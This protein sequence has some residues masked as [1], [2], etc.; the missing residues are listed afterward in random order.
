MRSLLPLVY[1]PERILVLPFPFY[2]KDLGCEAL[3]RLQTVLAYFPFQ[4]VLPLY[5]LALVERNEGRDLS[6]PY[7]SHTS[8]LLRQQSVRRVRSD[9]RRWSSVWSQ[10]P[11]FL[12]LLLFCGASF[13]SLSSFSHNP[14][15]FNPRFPLCIQSFAQSILRLGPFQ[16]FFFHRSLSVRRSFE[17]ILYPN[18]PFIKLSPPF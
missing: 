14:L 7:L 6:P 3:L 18:N 15:T 1:I 13:P 17:D 11:I 2:P 5:M 9:D 12:L 10:S 16:D 4:P 8:L